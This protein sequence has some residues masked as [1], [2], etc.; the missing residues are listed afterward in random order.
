H[1]FISFVSNR[2]EDKE[3]YLIQFIFFLLI[4]QFKNY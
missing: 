3:A 1:I 4:G 2:K